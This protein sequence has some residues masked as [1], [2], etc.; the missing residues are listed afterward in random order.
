MR[1]TLIGTSAHCGGDLEPKIELLPIAP[2]R[3]PT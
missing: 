2:Y 1:F 3:W